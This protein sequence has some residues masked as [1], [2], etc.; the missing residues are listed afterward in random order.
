MLFSREG[1]SGS[2]GT[3]IFST[4]FQWRMMYREVVIL[5]WMI[6]MWLDDPN[7]SLLRLWPTLL[8]RIHRYVHRWNDVVC[9]RRRTAIVEAEKNKYCGLRHLTGWA[10]SGVSPNPFCQ[11][12]EQWACKL[13]RPSS[14]FSHIAILIA[15][16]RQIAHHHHS[17]VNVWGDVCLRLLGSGLMGVLRLRVCYPLP[18]IPLEQ[19][20]RSGIS[21]WFTSALRVSSRLR[22]AWTREAA[23][24]CKNIPAN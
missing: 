2:P 14:G 15:Q 13:S 22:K 7:S 3:A 6:I 24:I 21:C 12:H 20:R 5:L 10:D 1:Y 23:V 17:Q 9:E 19:N 4:F 18:H 11:Q 16:R 8:G